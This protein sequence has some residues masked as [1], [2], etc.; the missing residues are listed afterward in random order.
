MKEEISYIIEEIGRV[1]VDISEIQAEQFY[2]YYELLVERNKVMNL[3]AITD[4]KEVVKKHFA[5]S[6]TLLGIHNMD[7]VRN[8]IDVGTGAGF[9]G[10]PLKIVCPDVKLTLLDSLGKRVKF[11]EDVAKKL[12]LRDVECVHSRT[13]D[14]AGNSYYR[15]QYDLVTARAVAAM[16]V[17]SEY[18]LPYVKIGGVFAAYKSGTIEEELAAAERAISVLGGKVRVTEKFQLDDMGRSIV[19][20]E[21]NR[22]TP[23]SY[24]RKAGTPS[25]SPIV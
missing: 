8:M 3:T 20:I 22:K 6:L 16:N 19:L 24:P 9:P 13:E 14:L 7:E 11:L 17:L 12:D 2:D 15:E 21:K 5:D 10:I 4:F 18:C 23:K 25:R 1:G